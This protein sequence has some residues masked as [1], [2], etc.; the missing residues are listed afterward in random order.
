MTPDILFWAGFK[1][2]ISR[3]QTNA[4]D[5]LATA[6]EVNVKDNNMSDIPNIGVNSCQPHSTKK[7]Q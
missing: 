6:A 2:V 4:F 7:L 3:A 5:R 1:P